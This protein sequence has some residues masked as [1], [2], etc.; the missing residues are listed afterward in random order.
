MSDEGFMKQALKL[1]RRGRPSPNPRVGAVIVKDGRV[2]AT[3]YHRA[4]GK[5]HAEAEALAQLGFRAP[6]ATLYVTLEPCVHYGRTPPCSETI[7]SSGIAEVVAGMVDP[8][9][10]V[11]GRGLT[12][13]REAGIHVRV[14]ILEAQCRELNRGFIK[15]M[16]TGLPYLTVKTA[17]TAD[18]KLATVSGASRWITSE[19]ARRAGH[20]LRAESD[21]II[22]GAG[23]VLADDP[24]LTARKGDHLQRRQPL[25]V[26]LD[27]TLRAPLEASV[28]TD[29]AAP[30]VV[31]TTG[32]AAAR[33][34]RML[35]ARGVEVEEVPGDGT[36][37]VSIPAALRS[38]AR[39]GVLYAMAEPGSTL[40]WS[41]AR[42]GLVDRY[43][44]FLAPK[45]FGGASA[46][47]VVGG[48]GVRRVDDAVHLRWVRVRRVG[49]DI[50]V[51]AVP[52]GN[53]D[54]A[55]KGTGD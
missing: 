4:A 28:F 25:R 51:E 55:G 35:E 17:A 50:L 44:F 36:G 34:R 2:L 26:V 24:S 38:L 11:R 45:L 10:Q 3:G 46:P 6:G 18:G 22:V 20:R 8:N 42:S 31:Y 9:P 12:R 7:V 29:Q 27:S 16:T 15:V 39:R 41:L 21:A 53:E 40:A 14:G 5:P 32:A 48:E 1:A 47:S 30:T 13:L 49:P 23:T 52:A 54:T 33:K 37:R 19:P 43:W